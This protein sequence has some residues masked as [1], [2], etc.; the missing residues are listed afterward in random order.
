MSSV[1]GWRPHGGRP[2]HDAPPSPMLFPSRKVRG[3]PSGSGAARR[4]SPAARGH[5]HCTL[6]SLYELRGRLVRFEAV[7]HFVEGLSV[8]V[9]HPLGRSDHEGKEAPGVVHRDLQRVVHG[10]GALLHLEEFVVLAGHGGLG[11]GDHA[12]GNGLLHARVRA[13]NRRQRLLREVKGGAV[14]PRAVQR[15][16]VAPHCAARPPQHPP[17]VLPPGTLLYLRG[18][19]LLPAGGHV[20]AVLSG[21][22]GGA[23]QVPIRGGG[24]G[25]AIERGER[26][27]LGSSGSSRAGC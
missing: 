3:C 10:D 4:Q 9:E 22:G 8:L 21:G 24:V 5:E 7:Q 13:R 26:K 14:L 11:A 23:A 12:R 1:R 17:R 16:A 2:A 19:L 20:V 6:L 25:G 18:R 15:Q 27:V